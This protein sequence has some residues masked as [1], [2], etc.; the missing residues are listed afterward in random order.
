MVPVSE[1][2]ASSNES[3]SKC[4]HRLFSISFQGFAVAPV[5]EEADAPQFGP[6]GRKRKVIR[7][8]QFAEG[9]GATIE[10]PAFKARSE[11]YSRNQTPN[12]SNEDDS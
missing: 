5:F 10:Q 9:K 2:A 3:C 8:E 11:A 7:R 12:T 1:W 6:L 4:G